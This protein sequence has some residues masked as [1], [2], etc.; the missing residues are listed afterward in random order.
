MIDK[1]EKKTK[2]IGS[3]ITETQNEKLEKLS[4][5]HGITKSSLIS[6]LLAE[7]Y[8]SITKNKTF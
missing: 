1:I 8:K 3:K 2:T 4:L 6:Q 5:K 7:G